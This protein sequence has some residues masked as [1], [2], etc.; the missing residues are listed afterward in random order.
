MAKK[1]LNKDCAIRRRSFED[2]KP[3]NEHEVPT[4]LKSNINFIRI[5]QI[6]NQPFTSK[7]PMIY[8]APNLFIT[9]YM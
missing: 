5:S 7:N 8:I 2:F 9:L 4:T 3:K 1:Q 6:R